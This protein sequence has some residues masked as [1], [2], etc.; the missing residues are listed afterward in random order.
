M[1][2]GNVIETK[3]VQM[4]MPV[5]LLNKIDNYA[6]SIG[7]NRSA[8]I[9]VLIASRLEQME[10]LTATQSANANI[11]DIMSNPVLMAKMLGQSK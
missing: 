11:Q 1:P 5:T 4:N 8:S 2:K 7:L 6:N 3:K 9:I 10:Q